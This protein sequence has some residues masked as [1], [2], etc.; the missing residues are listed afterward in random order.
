MCL[1]LLVKTMADPPHGSV[2]LI[3]S[4]TVTEVASWV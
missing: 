2:M 1:D 4:Y 3:A